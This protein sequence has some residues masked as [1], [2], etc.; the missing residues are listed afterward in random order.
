MEADP[1]FYPG[2]F[3]TTAPRAYRRSLAEGR[4]TDDDRRLIEEYLSERQA[5]RQ[6]G[7]QRVLKMRYHL[8]TWR[9]FIAPPY[10]EMTI[11]DVYAGLN[12]L[13][14]GA[15]RRGKP[16]KQNSKHDYIV[17]LKSFVLWLIANDYSTI[18][19]A[20]IRDIRVPAVDHNTTRP[21]ALLT[22][23]EIN[24]LLTGC[25]SVRDRA[26][27]AVLYES[28]ARVGEVARLRWRDVEFDKYGVR[29]YIHDTKV[30]QV[31]YARCTWAREMLAAWQ[32]VYPLP[33][34]PDAWVFLSSRKEA[35]NYDQIRQRVK[36]AA[37]RADLGKRVHL[38]L[39]RKSRA[40][41]MIQRNFQES[42]IKKMLW[43]NLNTSMFETYVVLSEADIDA[44]VLGKAGI[45]TREPEPD[46]LAPVPCPN[47]H[48]ICAPVSRFCSS[49][50]QALSVEAGEELEGAKD[51]IWRNPE[52]VLESAAEIQRRREGAAPPPTETAR[53]PA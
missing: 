47:C 18:P 39:F 10:A 16:F 23:D 46:P 27:V 4:L 2:Q 36:M 45:E 17:V 11:G 44:E 15:S 49:C 34:T 48:A 40:T 8:I 53:Q 3:R 5:T 31:R 51:I 6:I 24:R 19:T 42:V 22:P 28:G 26:I 14:T 7:N 43:G 41:H 12:A 25:R 52:T 9:R 21:E 35:M 29:I 50:G 30:N 20:K 33:V 38:H 13:Q 32:S 1:P 37:D